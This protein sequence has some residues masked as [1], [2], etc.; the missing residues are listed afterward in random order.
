[1]PGC[2]AVP[3]VQESLE[4]FPR[5]SSNSLVASLKSKKLDNWGPRFLAAF[6]P[7]S[8]PFRANPKVNKLHTPTVHLF[9]I[10]LTREIAPHANPASGEQTAWHYQPCL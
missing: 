8:T 2:V 6:C 10:H 9:M 7:S 4:T 3:T 5:P 1:M